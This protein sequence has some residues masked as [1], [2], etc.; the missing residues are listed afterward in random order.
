MFS[1]DNGTAGGVD[2][3]DDEF[4]V[5]GWNGGMRGQ[6][7]SQYDGGHRVPFFIRW[8]AGGLAHGRDVSVV[9][10]NVDVLPTLLDLSGIG[11]WEGRRLD[12]S[13]LVPVLR[14]P[15]APWPDRVMVTDSQ[16]L[17]IPEMWRQS[18]VLGDRWRLVDGVRLYDM[19]ADPE[20]RR[21][22]AAAHP[23]IVAELRLAYEA[24]WAI[25]SR[26]FDEEIPIVLG[27]PNARRPS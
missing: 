21:D 17:V 16:R 9:S 24:W 19:P 1:T 8:P 25:V 26:R 5:N 18:A 13:S 11:G 20:Q 15:D 3:D 22:V 12:G 6:K 10:A 23:E 4:V 2:V 7:G 27:D 14:E